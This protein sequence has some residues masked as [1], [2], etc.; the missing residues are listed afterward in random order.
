MQSLYR[1][2]EAIGGD[3]VVIAKYGGGVISGADMSGTMEDIC[4]V[5]RFDVKRPN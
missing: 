2:N 4:Y 3:Y 5:K 1:N